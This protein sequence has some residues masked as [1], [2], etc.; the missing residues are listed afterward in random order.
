MKLFGFYITKNNY[1]ADADYYKTIYLDL[2][3]DYES[4]KI[5]IEGGN[6]L[7]CPNCEN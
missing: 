3:K 1:K 4:K 6:K 2:F 5:C 7:E